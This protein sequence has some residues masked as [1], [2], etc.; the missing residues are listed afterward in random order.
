MSLLNEIRDRITAYL[1]DEISVYSL[2]GWLSQT[3]WDVDDLND[4][5]TSALFSEAEAL[6]YD[7]LH[8]QRYEQSLKGK[9]STTEKKTPMRLT[10]APPV[11]ASPSP[12]FLRALARHNPPL[13]E[14]LDLLRPCSE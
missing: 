8:S 1:N 9:L 3:G 12:R 2:S 11:P 13:S 4:P 5:E 7:H 6:V 14:Y 10:I